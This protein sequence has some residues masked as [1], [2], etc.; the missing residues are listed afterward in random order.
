MPRENKRRFLASRLPPAEPRAETMIR[1]VYWRLGNG[2]CLR[3]RR[4]GQPDEAPR[5][6]IALKGPRT[7]STRVQYDWTLPAEPDLSD[8]E[9][10]ATVAALFRAGGSHRIVKSRRSY[11]LDG[12]LWGVD[13]FHWENSGLIIAELELQDPGELRRV[14]VPSWCLR[15]ITADTDFDGES[16]AFHPYA[17]SLSAPGP[18]SR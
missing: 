11:L 15:E 8:E 9:R 7:R 17:H 1:Q 13:E 6:T 14:R 4:E 12:Q 3:L 10:T 16:L 2:W 5:D 18:R